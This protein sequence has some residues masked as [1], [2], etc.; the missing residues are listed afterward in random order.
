MEPGAVVPNIFSVIPFV[1][2]LGLIAAGPLVIKKER[3]HFYTIVSV[4][5]AFI[6]AGY[7]LFWLHDSHSVWA[8]F[9]EYCSFIVLLSSLY[10]VTG[11][12]LITTES[13]GSAAINTVFL[14]FGAILSSVIGTTGAS[15]ILVRPYL[16]MNGKNL[17]PYHVV[18]FIFLVSNIGG[19]LTPI[20][21]P[22]LFLGFLRGIPFFWVFGRI[23][24]IWLLTVAMVLI[25]FWSFDRKNGA[26]DR[27]IIRAFRTMRISGKRN[28]IF[29]LL[30]IGSVF[31]DRN[32]LPWLP[33]IKPIGIR[34]ILLLS[35]LV[36]AY[37]ITP[38]SVHEENEFDF[39]PM[40]EVA[41]LF[42]GLF[43]TM[44]PALQL[45]EK[46]AQTY[47][48]SLNVSSFFWGAGM[49]SSVL[50]NA[51]AYLNFLSAAMG[52]FGLQSGSAVQVQQFLGMGGQ[53]VTA[54]SIAC[55]FFGAMTYIGNGPNFLVKSLSERSGV[56]MPSF[57]GY[58]TGYTIPVLLPI[59]VIIWL[60]FVR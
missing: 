59:I 1:L 54:I 32:Y 56:K 43:M 41:V 3:E 23:W 24:F 42:F 15:M 44:V 46:G 34:E 4:S 38:R 58:I 11:G 29:L 20:G 19:A 30:I 22:P 12:I 21:D 36:A 16:R 40:K 45:I 52:K 7:Y 10:V 51:P 60:F 33:A 6:T 57:F 14:F 28:F 49:L 55:V 35:I 26:G 50:D 37:K 18:F 13:R 48:S 17:K 8:C 2:L 27:N 9:S 39:A 31:L 47:G 25:V 53:Y 5:F